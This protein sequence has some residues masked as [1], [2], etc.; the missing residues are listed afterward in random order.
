MQLRKRVL[1]P[2]RT[3]KIETLKKYLTM[4]WL[5]NWTHRVIFR[6]GLSCLCCTNHEHK[7]RKSNIYLVN[8]HELPQT[9]SLTDADS[10][11]CCVKHVLSTRSAQ[12]IIRLLS[13]TTGQG[14]TEI[15]ETNPIAATCLAHDLCML[16]HSSLQ[17]YLFRN[18]KP[19]NRELQRN[20]ILKY[21]LTFCLYFHISVY[22]CLCF[23]PHILK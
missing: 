16:L 15:C 12:I 22:F 10:I 20:G 6:L 21:H 4:H 17:S 23:E 1:L 5:H 8:T 14:Q 3:F 13:E 11:I 19:T 18:W 9:V 7:R 2:S